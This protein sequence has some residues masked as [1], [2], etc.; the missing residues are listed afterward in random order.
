VLASN[1]MPFS[2]KITVQSVPCHTPPAL[3]DELRQRI[4]C[5]L[6]L[7]SRCPCE[8]GLAGRKSQHIATSYL[9][10]NNN[11]YVAEIEKVIIN[12]RLLLE[13]SQ[14]QCLSRNCI[15]DFHPFALLDELRQRITSV[16]HLVSRCPCKGNW[17][18]QTQGA[19]ST[20]YL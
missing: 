9:T 5:V 3:M 8:K 6:R 10:S 14:S 18:A 12:E 17:L 7:V 19:L 20:S 13:S 15:M 4:T 11:Q 2:P 16:L 1:H